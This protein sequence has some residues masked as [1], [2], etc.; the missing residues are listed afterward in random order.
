MNFL[1]R[2]KNWQLLL[3]VI[4]LPLLFMVISIVVFD[5]NAQSHSIPMGLFSLVY[6]L[7]FI[8]WNISVIRFFNSKEKILTI[9]QLRWLKYLGVFLILYIIYLI[10]PNEL[11]VSKN[12]IIR[13]I[14]PL[15][16]FI[17]GFTVFYVVFWFLNQVSIRIIE[18]C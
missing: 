6:Y 2:I 13:V 1:L 3:I 4:F 14:S 15:I 11:M 7:I 9:K 16:S 8:F 18:I 10:F 17:S 5:D 12:I